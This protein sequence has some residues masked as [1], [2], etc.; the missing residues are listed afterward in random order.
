MLF[1][2][3]LQNT[4][5]KFSAKDRTLILAEGRSDSG[6]AS[7]TQTNTYQQHTP[8]RYTRTAV[9]TVK[10]TYEKQ[11]GFYSSIIK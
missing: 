1:M 9:A 8:G 2:Q 11:K 7:P 10:K 4:L 6:E 3:N 5:R